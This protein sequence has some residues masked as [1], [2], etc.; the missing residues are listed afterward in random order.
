MAAEEKNGWKTVGIIAIVV[1]IAAVIALA[2]FLLGRGC[3]DE[4]DEDT[5]TTQTQPQAQPSPAGGGASE[6]SGGVADPELPDP[7]GG[8]PPEVPPVDPPTEE[9]YVTGEGEGSTPCVGG[10]MTTTR[11]TYYSDGSTDTVT[12]TEPC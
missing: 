8:D 10:F 2:V 1:L 4:K 5:G 12:I 9:R 7:G 3:E 11:T 6:P